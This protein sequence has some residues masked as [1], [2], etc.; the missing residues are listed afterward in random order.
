MAS[1]FTGEDI[2]KL[3]LGY[4]DPKVLSALHAE[5]NTIKLA[6]Q[7][8]DDWHYDVCE[9]A[10]IAK[11][12]DNFLALLKRRRQ[13]RLDEIQK[14]WQTTKVLL[15][16]QPSCLEKPPSNGVLWGSFMRLARNFS[17]S[18]LVAC[19]GSYVTDDE[20]STQ[21]PPSTSIGTRLTKLPRPKMGPKGKMATSG[22]P[23]SSPTASQCRTPRRESSG[24]SGVRRNTRLQ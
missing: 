23:E 20:R 12:N 7:D 2:S 19:F 6:I 9:A 18:S 14:A 10:K 21:P 1:K 17:Y 5:Y 16:D 13:Q 4:E 3:R 24:Q 8:P 22:V 11:D 15:T